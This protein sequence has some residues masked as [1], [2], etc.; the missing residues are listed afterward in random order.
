MA[1]FDVSQS[2]TSIDAVSVYVS[3]ISVKL[4]HTASR[5]ARVYLRYLV[6]STS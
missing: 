1:I 2:M 6:I 4:R 3:G 5:N